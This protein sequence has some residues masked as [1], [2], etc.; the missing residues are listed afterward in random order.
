MKIGGVWAYRHLKNKID[1]KK[2]YSVRRV[3]EKYGIPYEDVRFDINTEDHIRFIKE[4]DPDIILSS[5]SLYFGREILALPRICCINRHSGL[6]PRNGGLWP[7]FQA[8]RKGE[9]ETGV[10]VHTMEAQI[11]SG[12]V[13]SQIKVPV[14][15]GETVWDIYKECFKVSSKAVMIALDKIRDH[16]Y[17]RADCGYRR[18]YYS[19][20]TKEQWK[21]FRLRGGKYI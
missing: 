14:R 6:L 12:V 18:E 17:A 4:K 2:I 7:G 5:Q 9:K 13:L 1:R 15:A 19:F 11:D 3:L 20:P 21:E 16:D 8:V 10:S